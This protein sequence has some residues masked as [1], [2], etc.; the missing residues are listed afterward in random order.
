MNEKSLPIYLSQAIHTVVAAYFIDVARVYSSAQLEEYIRHVKQT[1]E[2][3]TN[4][5]D[6]FLPADYGRSMVQKFETTR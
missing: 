6:K 2:Y 1:Y 4:M 5:T 3:I